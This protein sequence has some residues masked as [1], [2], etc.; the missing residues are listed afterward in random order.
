MFEDRFEFGVQER[1]AR[2]F[3]Y[4]G[5]FWRAVEAVEKVPRLTT[6]GKAFM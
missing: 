5:V 1:V 2:R 6:F 3:L 4:D